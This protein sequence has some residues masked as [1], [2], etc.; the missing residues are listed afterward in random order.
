MALSPDNEYLVSNGEGNAIKLWD[1]N[2]GKCIQNSKCAHTDSIHSLAFSSDGSSIISS[3]KDGTIRIWDTNK[4]SSPARVLRQDGWL[5]DKQNNFLLWI[6]PDYR[7][8]LL[9]NA[10]HRDVLGRSFSTKVEFSDTFSERSWLNWT[11]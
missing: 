10:A 4:F 1:V 7:A 6:P 11:E 5:M 2:T 9:Y 8:S 3:S